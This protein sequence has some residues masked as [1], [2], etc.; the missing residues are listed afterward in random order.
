V[1]VLRAPNAPTKLIPVR[2]PSM[3]SMLSVIAFGRDVI[4]GETL[5]YQ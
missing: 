4:Q 2:G 1:R 5:G 3:N